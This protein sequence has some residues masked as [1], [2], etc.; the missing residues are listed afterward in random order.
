MLKALQGYLGHVLDGLGHM[1]W[2][3]LN[4]Y[5]EYPASGNMFMITLD[6]DINCNSGF[7]LLWKI[8]FYYFIIVS[9]EH[10]I[11]EAF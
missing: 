8:Y 6:M 3:I 7:F 9:V 2:M 4:T 11:N 1:S 10:M 5:P